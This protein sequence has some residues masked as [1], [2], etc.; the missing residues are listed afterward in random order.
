MVT[1]DFKKVLIKA[2]EDPE[3][4]RLLADSQDKALKKLG[5]SLT[6][7]E[8]ESLREI[9]TDNLNSAVSILQKNVSQTYIGENLNLET[10]LSE[11]E[12]TITS[13]GL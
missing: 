7:N 8:R 10:R 6:D 4:G 9:S 5:I 1:K 3:F 12:E 11:L 2:L 13:R